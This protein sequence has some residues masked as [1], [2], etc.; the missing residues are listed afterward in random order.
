MLGRSHRRWARIV[1]ALTGSRS[2][3]RRSFG[4]R[5]V[6][7]GLAVVLWVLRLAIVFATALAEPR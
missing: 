7:P 4:G 6:L 2:L 5:L 1:L 3:G